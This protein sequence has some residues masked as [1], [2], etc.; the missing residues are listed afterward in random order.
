M[1]LKVSYYDYVKYEEHFSTARNL[2][3]VTEEEDVLKSFIVGQLLRE[4]GGR[5]N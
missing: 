1:N 2:V 4:F 5:R 3:L